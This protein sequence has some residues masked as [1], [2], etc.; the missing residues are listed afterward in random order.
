MTCGRHQQPVHTKQ[1]SKKRQSLKYKQW[2]RKLCEGGYASLNK[3]SLDHNIPTVAD[4][5]EIPVD[6]FLTLATNYCNHE[7]TTKYLI[8]NW[9]HPLFLKAHVEAN[10]KDN[11][12]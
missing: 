10:K 3:I 7:G 1:L 9:I 12:K 2:K 4:F 11:T 8:V 5:M 6:I